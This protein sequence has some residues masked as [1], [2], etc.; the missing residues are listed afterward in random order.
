MRIIVTGGT[1]MLGRAL[2]DDLAADGH[3]VIILTRSPGR[4]SGLPANVRAAGW[5]A[6]SGD[7]W[8]EL[9]DSNTA[10]VNLAAENI[11][12][13][14]FLPDRWTASKRQ[15]IRQSRIDAGR[16]VVDG[17]RRADQKLQVVIQASATGYYGW[18]ESG[19]LSE[20]H[21]SGDDFLAS[22]VRDWEASSAPVEDEGVRRAIIRTGVVLTPYGGPV[23][24]LLVPYRFFVGGPIGGGKQ[25]WSWIHPKDVVRGIRFLIERTDAHGP[26][27]LVAPEPVTNDDFGKTLGRV[28][29][30]PHFFPLPAFALRLPLGEVADIVLKGQPVVPQRLLAMGFDYWFPGLEEALRDLLQQPGK[31]AAGRARARTDA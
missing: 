17:V 14:R 22:V 26:F 28:L 30:R 29:G 20:E 7:G 19:R 1:G 2:V 9:I 13:E 6:R 21:P 11:G 8:A 12:G 24:R 27:N 25:W 31:A 16:A 3:D 23:R 18:H 4:A 15:R 10:I 5:D